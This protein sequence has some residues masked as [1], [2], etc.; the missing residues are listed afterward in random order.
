MPDCSIAAFATG[1]ANSIGGVSFKL[2][3]KLPI[4]ERFAATIKTSA[5]NDFLSKS[6]H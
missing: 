2:P 3:P 1:I 5:I 6:C 4:A